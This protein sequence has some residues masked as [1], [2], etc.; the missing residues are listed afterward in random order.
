MKRS[1]DALL[2]TLVCGVLASCSSAGPI[3]IGDGTLEPQPQT[4]VSASAGATLPIPDAGASK[5]QDQHPPAAE[6]RPADEPNA[7]TAQFAANLDYA[8]RWI[9]YVEAFEFLDGSD[10]VQLTLERSG[11]GTLIV[12]DS[13][14]PD[15][16]TRADL[17]F[18]FLPTWGGP[19]PVLALMS[20][21]ANNHDLIPGFRYEISGVILEGQRLRGSSHMYAPI[22][23][24]CA[25]QTPIA[26]DDGDGTYYRCSPGGPPDGICPP[27]EV[28]E[29]RQRID[30]DCSDQGD[31][32]CNSRCAC[33]ERGCQLAERHEQPDLLL[34]VTFQ[35]ADTLAGALGTSHSPRVIL[36]RAGDPPP[37]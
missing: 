30:S 34:D 33:A 15:V 1:T 17:Y 20:M 12:G 2:R 35:G 19:D 16:P 18:P 6:S 14:E 36:M 23:P 37:R 9:G 13:A 21:L 26:H 8:G 28:F 11:S 25:L 31:L 22:R 3:D 32:V 5:S 29:D 27:V 7:S 24:W 4:G 10:K